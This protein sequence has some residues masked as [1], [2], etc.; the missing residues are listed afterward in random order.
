MKVFILICTILVNAYSNNYKEFKQDCKNIK[1]TWSENINDFKNKTQAIKNTKNIAISMLTKE[2]YGVAMD[3]VDEISSNSDGVNR[4][5]TSIFYSK[6]KSS[7]L[8]FYKFKKY[9]DKNGNMLEY[10]HNKNNNTIKVKATLDCSRL[11]YQKLQNYILK[12]ELMQ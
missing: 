10:K 9:K 6:L 2:W 3:T 4:N 8:L 1:I 11:I 7:G 12:M 5:E